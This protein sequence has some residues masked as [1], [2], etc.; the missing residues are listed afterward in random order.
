MKKSNY[1][2]VLRETPHVIVVLRRFPYDSE[3][4][5]IQKYVRS[6]TV[7]MTRKQAELY[8]EEQ[9]TYEDARLFFEQEVAR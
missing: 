6:Q 4:C 3:K 8:I 2:V 9:K 5:E 7:Q 1:T